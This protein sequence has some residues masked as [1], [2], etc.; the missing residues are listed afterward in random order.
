[1][2]L[3]SPGPNM[4]LSNSQRIMNKA[5]G[6]G[7]EAPPK[8]GRRPAGAKGMHNKATSSISQSNC[9]SEKITHTRANES[10]AS[11]QMKSASRGKKFNTR[12]TA[13]S[14]PPH[15]TAAIMAGSALIQNRLGR[16]SRVSS[17]P[18][19]SARACSS[20]RG[21]GS[22]PFGPISALLS[23]MIPEKMTTKTTPTARN[24]AQRGQ[25]VLAPGARPEKSL[26]ACHPVDNGPSDFPVLLILIVR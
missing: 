7:G 9:G 18:V 26:T 20:S 25:R 14:N 24:I 4:T 19:W 21:R 17:T 23:A 5:R 12:A 16:W 3:A 6:D 15:S 11:Q 22:N 13:A 10:N 1:M 2:S 8:P